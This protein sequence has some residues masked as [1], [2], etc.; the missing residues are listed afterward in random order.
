MAQKLVRA[1]RIGPGDRALDVACGTGK[2]T[3]DLYRAAQPAG[4]ALGIDFSAGMIA[5]ARERRPTDLDGL[6]FQQGDALDLPVEDDSFDAA[7]IAYGM[8]NLVD[9]RQ[10]FAEMARAVR[11][12]GTVVCLE[13]HTPTSL[14]GRMAAVWF[15][16]VVPLIGK[17]VG[18]GDAYGYLAN[19]VKGYPAP[20]RIAEIMRDAGLENV[21]WLGFMGGIVALH[22]GTVPE[23]GA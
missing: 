13:I 21:D 15:D 17:L 2:V 14:I 20:E 12:G 9:Y 4:S 1:T 8:R 6:G 10:G 7:T 19:S 16:H 23:P 3:A 22:V 18:Q 5:H 11:P